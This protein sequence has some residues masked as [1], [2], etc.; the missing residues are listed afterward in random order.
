LLVVTARTASMNFVMFANAINSVRML[1]APIRRQDV[2]RFA[3]A[4][5]VERCQ[6]F[7]L[8]PGTIS[9]QRMVRIALLAGF[10]LEDGVCV[11]Q[12]N[13]LR[14]SAE[15]RRRVL[16]ATQTGRWAVSSIASLDGIATGTHGHGQVGV[17][18]QPDP[19]GHARWPSALPAPASN[20]AC[21]VRGLP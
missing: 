21:N 1:P 11:G 4:C 18:R 20:R 17:F 12:A 6:R 15:R 14:W 3:H 10:T 19:T 9:R 2:R 5:G 7:V 13:L 16:R 8:G